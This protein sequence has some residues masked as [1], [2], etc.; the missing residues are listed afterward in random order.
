MA[1]KL[2]DALEDEI[3]ALIKNNMNRVEFPTGSSV[4]R[5]KYRK[6]ARENISIMQFGQF[7]WI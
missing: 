2:P 4:G 1:A 7:R 6:D 5:I 3:E